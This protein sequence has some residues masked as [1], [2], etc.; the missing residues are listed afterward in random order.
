MWKDHMVGTK[1]QQPG[2]MRKEGLISG[3]VHMHMQNSIL[4]LR[5]RQPISNVHKKG[6]SQ[7]KAASP[8]YKTYSQLCLNYKTLLHSHL[9][10]SPLLKAS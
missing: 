4:D 6:D 7:S 1:Y 8:R 2:G 3:D 5:K 9:P 10:F